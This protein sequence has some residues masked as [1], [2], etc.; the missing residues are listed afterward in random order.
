MSL[1]NLNET[2]KNIA[3]LRVVG[4][5]SPRAIAH[6]LEMHPQ[7]VYRIIE[8]QLFQEYANK[9]REEYQDS[10]MIDAK[11]ALSHIMDNIPDIA[12]SLVDIALHSRSDSV[13][14]RACVDSLAVCGIRAKAEK[15]DKEDVLPHLKV[16]IGGGTESNAK[17]G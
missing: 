12:K 6:K 13:K 8:D 14:E 17:A 16:E 9:L 5:L 2:H 11:E 1:Q 10:I 3:F 4:G 15:D 7:S